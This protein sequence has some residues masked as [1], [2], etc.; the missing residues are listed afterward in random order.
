VV[1]ISDEVKKANKSLTKLIEAELIPVLEIEEG[2]FIFED[3]AIAKFFGR[4][5]PEKKFLG[6]NPLEKAQVEMF[7]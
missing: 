7:L 6:A 1:I 4:L 3:V 5:A 2:N